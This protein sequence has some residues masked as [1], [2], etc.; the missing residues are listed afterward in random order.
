MEA[1]PASPSP[2]PTVHAATDLLVSAALTEASGG[3]GITK[4]GP[5]TMTLT[6]PNTYTGKTSVNEGTLRINGSVR[7]A[8][9]WNQRHPRPRSVVIG[10]LTAA[11]AA[12]SGKLAIELAAPP[13]TSSTSPA[14][15]TSPTPPST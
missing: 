8:S 14:T 6:G 12:I 2:W 11:S 1:T 13:P 7:G 5:G 9:L 4:N 10:T 15:S 3:M